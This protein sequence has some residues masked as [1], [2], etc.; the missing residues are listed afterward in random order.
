MSQQGV[1]G[2]RGAA[3]CGERVPGAQP[4]PPELKCLTGKLSEEGL[5]R[6]VAPLELGGGGYWG[7]WGV[8]RG[9][10]IRQQQALFGGRQQRSTGLDT[11]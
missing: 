7:R 2:L 8:Q 6:M 9:A 10:V 5:Q 11:V 4:P 3:G 1:G